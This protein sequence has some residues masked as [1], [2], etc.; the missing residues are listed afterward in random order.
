MSE[1]KNFTSKELAC[2]CCG[3][4]GTTQEF[5]DK[6]Q[7]FRDAVGI[8]LTITSAYRCE[9]HNAAVGG[10]KNSQ[11]IR[12]TAAD[13]KWDDIDGNARSRMLKCAM[14][15]FGGIGIDKKFIHIDSRANE[16]MWVY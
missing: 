10:A 4:D 5:A 16:T 7:K 2:K 12:G 9:K 6:L 14:L 1:T 11:H 8:P 13:I 15:I 3:V